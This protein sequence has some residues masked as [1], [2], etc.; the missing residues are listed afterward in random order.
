M[1]ILTTKKDD[2]YLRYK[3]TY[4]W[5]QLY[6]KKLKMFRCFPLIKVTKQFSPD[7]KNPQMA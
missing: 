5:N 7:S 1:R 2:D 6:D 3:I 4:I